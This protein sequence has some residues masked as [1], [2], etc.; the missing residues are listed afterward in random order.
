[1][2][3]IRRSFDYY[4]H[5]LYESPVNR[6][7]LSGGVASIPHL[8]HTLSDELSIKDVEVANPAESALRLGD[9][10]GVTPLTDHPA[11]FV[12]AVGLAA[13]GASAL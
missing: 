11:Q 4:E 12:V 6:L 7:I 8:R 3:E 10:R 9:R 5:E 13:R 2:S 1:V